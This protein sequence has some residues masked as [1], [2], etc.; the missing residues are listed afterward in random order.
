MNKNI[1]LSVRLKERGFAPVHEAFF[2]NTLSGIVM[3]VMMDDE[4]EDDDEPEP[5]LDDEDYLALKRELEQDMCAGG[6]GRCNEVRHG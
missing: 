6:C 3:K 2:D 4:L 1:P 5:E